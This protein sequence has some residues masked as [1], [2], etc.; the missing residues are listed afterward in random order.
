[1][2]AVLSWLL[3]PDEANPG[4]RYFALTRLLGKSPDDAA[5]IEA[6]AAIMHTGPVPRILAAQDT[7]GWWEKPGA[8]YSS[9]YRGTV[10]QIIA[11]HRL[12]ADGKDSRVQKAYEYVLQHTLNANGAFGWSG[13]QTVDPPGPSSGLHCLN[14]N[15]L[16]AMISFGLLEDERVQRAIEWQALSITGDDPGFPYFKS[17]T[18][19]PGFR[20]G[21][22]AGLPCAWGAN[23]AMLALL[24]VPPTLRSARV[25]DA[26]DS[27][28]T[29]L[30]SK[31]PAIADYPNKNA[32]SAHWFR[33]GLSLSYWSDVLETLEVLSGLGYGAD[34]R[35]DAAFA[36]V[37]GKRDS[38]GRWRMEDTINGRS[39]ARIENKGEAS[40]WVTLRA[41][42][43]LK[44]AGRQ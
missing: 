44:A 19:G 29:F 10:W 37:L 25:R 18:S 27:G 4:V 38:S 8:G 24:A 42:S 39:R 16:A 26:L 13:R 6:Q 36:L 35:L 28:A 11:L 40:K 2:D 33:F 1:M 23:K 9:K 17:G 31:D 14:G 30:L 7:A 34:S 5:V 22:N 21:S 3:E 32:V 15:L 41:L 43:V 20:C 12:G